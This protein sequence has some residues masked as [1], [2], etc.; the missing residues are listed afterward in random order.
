MANLPKTTDGFWLPLLVNLAYVAIIIAHLWQLSTIPRGFYVDELST[1]Y[2]AI[3]IAQE[4]KDEFGHYFPLYFRSF[5]D[6][7]QPIYIYTAAIVFKLLG[8]SE[9]NLR[10]V[11]FFYFMLFLISIH[12]I[13][14]KLFSRNQLILLYTLITAGFL[15]W[16]FTLSRIAFDVITQLAITTLAIFFLLK[17]FHDSPQQQKTYSPILAG[18]LLGLSIYSY[19]TSRFL[20]FLLFLITLAVY[21]RRSTFKR[22]LIFTIYFSLF[23]APFLIYNFQHHGQLSAYVRQMMYI[24]DPTP[25]LN[26]LKTFVRYY[27]SYF[28]PSYLLRAGDF[29]NLRH[30][31]GF[32]GQLFITTF[33][34]ALL[35]A[36]SVISKHTPYKKFIIFLI[37]CSITA[38]VAAAITIPYLSPHA[39]RSTLL[40]LFLLLLSIFGF[41]SLNHVLANPAHR[42]AML[43]I[44][45]ITLI[46]Q[47]YQYTNHY[48]TIYPA[49]SISAFE[50]Y[51]FKSDLRRALQLTPQ[52]IT[53]S[54]RSNN[55][56]TYLSFYKNIIPN[57][58]NIPIEV[59]TPQS[60][61]GT[62]VIYFVHFE[63][64]PKKE[65]LP[66]QDFSHPEND[67]QLR[68]Y[69]KP[70]QLDTKL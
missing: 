58:H 7:K 41:Q 54:N 67:T 29:S 1:G 59:E 70:R 13:T 16:F 32:G 51:D 4:G 10:L 28:S 27:F 42:L 40:G 65:S 45:F 5:G 66:F 11:S 55:P 46:F 69:H 18:S 15:P 57:P 50:S 23:A 30:H 8:I 68:C 61:P 3:T 19:T 21:A 56:Q 64:P 25:W 47:A 62:C 39:L 20:S 22:C 35:G 34:L 49:N 37:I 2:N 44:I 17:T 60:S 26:R 14:A 31:S 9:F 24:D 33:V 63:A 6:Y 12:L 36:A 48:F 38:P 52:K 53:I 43:I